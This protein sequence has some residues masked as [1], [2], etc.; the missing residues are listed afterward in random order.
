MCKDTLQFQELVHTSGAEIL[1][2]SAV[3]PVA[4]RLEIATRAYA[5]LKIL[6][7]TFHNVKPCK[8]CFLQLKASTLVYCV[9]NY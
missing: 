9:I 5:S 3:A 6:N 4:A 8:H 2:L 7:V 1:L